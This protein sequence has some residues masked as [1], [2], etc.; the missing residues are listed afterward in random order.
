MKVLSLN[1]LPEAL[2]EASSQTVDR[3]RK[4][5]DQAQ[6][7]KKNDTGSKRQGFKKSQ[8]SSGTT[9]NVSRDETS[10]PLQ[11]QIVDSQKLINMLSK[12]PSA[13]R[14]AKRDAF[15][16]LAVNSVTS[17]PEEKIKKV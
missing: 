9:E 10:Q 13:S 15:K 6:Q 8:E 3:P 5:R 2:V 1:I 16:K 4:N 11:S 14:T 7:D 12:K 17:S